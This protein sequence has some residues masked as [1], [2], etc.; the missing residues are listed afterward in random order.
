MMRGRSRRLIG[1]ARPG[2]LL[3]QLVV[4]RPEPPTYTPRPPQGWPG[5]ATGQIE[6]EHG[7][8]HGGGSS[9]SGSRRAVRKRV[10]RHSS[11]HKISPGDDESDVM[12]G[13]EHGVKDQEHL[14]ARTGSAPARGRTSGR[15]V[16]GNFGIAVVWS[17]SLLA[18]VSLQVPVRPVAAVCC[19]RL[20]RRLMI[21]GGVGGAVRVNS[22]T[23]RRKVQRTVQ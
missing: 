17:S 23:S 3:H 4:C 2:E 13:A 19:S 18:R 6:S 5:I 8:R 20:S 1:G 22:R 21:G 10:D 12:A 15:N 14:R 9:I 11:P 7:D 16:A